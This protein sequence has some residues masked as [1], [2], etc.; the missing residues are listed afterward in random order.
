M[1]AP[2][3]VSADSELG[4]TGEDKTS[5]MFVTADKPG[6]LVDVLTVFRDASI[7]LSHI[8]KRPSG[9]TNW[10]YTFFI[11]CRGHRTDPT[12]IK[13]LEDAHAHCVSL[14]V[15]GSYPRATRIL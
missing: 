6:A 11:D 1:G 12:M 4:N 10:E 2:S 13:A 14:K 7:N 9:R 15:L 5:V 3:H 8:D